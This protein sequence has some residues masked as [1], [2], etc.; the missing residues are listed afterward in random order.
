[1]R[2]LVT[3][4]RQRNIAGVCLEDK[5]FPKTNS[6]INGEMQPLADIEEFCGKIKAA[7]DAQ[8]DDDFVVVARI[9]ALIA[10]WGLGEALRRAEAYKMA[11]AD[12]ILIHSKRTDFSEIDEFMKRWGNNHPVIIVP[13]KYYST[14]TDKFKDVGISMVIWANHTLRSSISAMQKTAKQIFNDE[15]L[16]NVEDKITSVAEIFRLQGADELKVAE[17]KYLPT[18]GKNVN[19]IILAAAQGNKFGELTKDIQKHF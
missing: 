6:F 14:P 3:K 2:R 12:A 16:I 10:G 7:K 1:V 4:L 8:K 15:S 13:T 18:A 17:T 19:A 5:L 11:G 9:E